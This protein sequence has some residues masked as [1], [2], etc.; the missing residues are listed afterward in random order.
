M[1]Q[2]VTVAAFQVERVFDGCGIHQISTILHQDNRNRPKTFCANWKYAVYSRQQ[3]AILAFG[4][5]INIAIKH[6]LQILLLRILQ[7]L[8]Q[9]SAI[10]GEE[11]E[12]ATLA[13]T[14]SRIKHI[15]PI[16]IKI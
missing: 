4:N 15:A 9:E 3:R 16:Q 11:E 2:P 1:G 14:L 8:D 12:G 7:S 6:I 5:M 13:S 10:V